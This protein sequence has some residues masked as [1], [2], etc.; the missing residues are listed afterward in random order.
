MIRTWHIEAAVVALV[1]LV[2]AFVSGG[3]WV[4]V[5]GAGAVLAGFMHCQIADRLHE[6]H[7]ASLGKP[8][9]ECA[10]WMW[11][12]WV[13]KE[14]L[15]IGYFVAHHSYSALAGCVLF[16]AYPLWRRW[17]RSRRPLEGA[18]P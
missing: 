5:V 10:R 16:A 2:V 14:A 13:A 12:Y 17:W 15:W 18:R 4:E 7:E 8:P 3:G 11:R 9:V 6:A 1:L